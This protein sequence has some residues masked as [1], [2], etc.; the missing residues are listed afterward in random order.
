[1]FVRKSTEKTKVTIDKPDGMDVDDEESADPDVVH[2]QKVKVE[3]LVNR[4][5]EAQQLQV[6][7]ENAISSAVNL[8]I[9]K[10]EKD[11]IKA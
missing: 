4:Y 10:D 1:M 2:R 7:P 5:L 11:A 6:I 9:E 3:T 8:F